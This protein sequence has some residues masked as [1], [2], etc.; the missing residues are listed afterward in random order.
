MWTYL[1]FV[2]LL[3]VVFAGII[4][5]TYSGRRKEKIERPKYR[6]LEDEDEQ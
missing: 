3:T 4:L 6:M 5:Y 1:F 2:A